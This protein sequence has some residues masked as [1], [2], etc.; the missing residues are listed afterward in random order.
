MRFRNGTGR[1][2]ASVLNRVTAAGQRAANRADVTDRM[3]SSYSAAPERQRWFLAKITGHTAISGFTNRWEYDWE[4]VGLLSTGAVSPPTDAFI[5]STHGKAWNLCELV[6]DGADFE[7]PGWDLRNIDP[8][9]TFALRPIREC[10]VMMWVHRDDDAD[11]R[12]IFFASNVV[13]GV[14]PVEE[15]P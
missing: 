12:F 14:C 2:N 3:T 15:S 8:L 5:S 7:G 10:V 9:S 11:A 13:D 4:Q 6:N 1:L